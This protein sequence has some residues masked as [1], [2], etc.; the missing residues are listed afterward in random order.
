MKIAEKSCEVV[1]IDL[2][3]RMIEQAIQNIPQDSNLNLSFQEGSA[4]HLPSE[5]GLFDVI[6]STFMLSELHPFE[7]Q[8][9]LRE[10]WDHLNPNGHILLADEFLPNGIAKVGFQLKQ[11]WYK[12]QLKRSKSGETDP[13]EWF[14]HFLVPIGYKII[15]KEQWVQN[16]IR[17]FELQKDPSKEMD[18]ADYYQPAPHAFT[19]LKAFGRS[20]RCLLTGQIDEVPIEPGLYQ[21]GSPTAE[22]PIIVTANYEYTYFRVMRDLRGIDAWVLCV[23]SDGINVWCGSG[24]GILEIYKSNKRFKLRALKKKFHIVN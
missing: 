13:L 9:F 20:L 14:E 2:N 1:G 5:L 19:G 17:I 23:D 12:H 22:S 10:I 6:V 16:S 4:L 21:S 7:Q 15:S 24:V 18:H 11:W 8:I 3:P